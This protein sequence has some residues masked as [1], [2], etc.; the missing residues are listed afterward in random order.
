MLHNNMPAINDEQFQHEFH[1][2]M[3]LHHPNIVQLVGYCYETQRQHVDFQGRM[4]FG[5]TTYRALYFEYMHMGSLQRHISEELH[6]LDWKTRYKI[7]KGA[8]EGLKY[9]HEGCKEPIYYLDLKPDNILLDENMIPKLADFGLSKLFGEEQTRVTYNPAGTFGYMPPEYLFGQVVSKKLD[10]FSLGVVITKVRKNWR[11]RLEAT[12][13]SSRILEAYYEQVSICTEIGLS[14]METDR[15]NRPSIVD[16]IQR[17]NET[18]T[19]IEKAISW[20]ANLRSSMQVI[21]SQSENDDSLVKAEAFARNKAIQG[22]ETCDEFP[23]L[24][25]VSGAAWRRA[26]EMP[27][28]GV[29]VVLVL[30]VQINDVTWGILMLVESLGPNDRLS[31]LFMGKTM[32]QVMELTYMSHDGRDIARR[33]IGEH[34]DDGYVRPVLHAAA[35]VHPHIHFRDHTLLYYVSEVPGKGISNSNPPHTFS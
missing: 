10:V 24:V 32:Q 30:D 21:K 2:L 9:L 26:E 7:I 35:K 13:T 1:N 31:I 11:E 19:M 29:N 22:A 3:R 34:V 17:L 23:V 4:V 8:C 12:C 25:R 6:G 33:K 20:S 27:R 15:H 5:E 16:I 28:A 14:S 18:E